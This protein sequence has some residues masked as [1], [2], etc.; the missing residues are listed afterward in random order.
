MTD[1]LSDSDR[2]QDL[3]L[4]RVMLGTFT[5]ELPRLI[6]TLREM[7]AGYPTGHE[8]SSQPELCPTCEGATSIEDDL[9]LAEIC[10]DCEGQGYVTDSFQ[11]RTESAAFTP[12]K[13]RADLRKIDTL[14]R[15]A[16]SVADQLDSV[17]SEW[18]APDGPKLEKAKEA[19]PGCVSCKR[20]KIKI[21]DVW[22]P[23]WEPRHLLSGTGDKAHY[24]ER[25][26]W[27]SDWFLANG[28]NP[29]VEILR[30]RHQGVRI[31]SAVLAKYGVKT[32]TARERQARKAS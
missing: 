25:C 15:Q 26:R 4:S 20:L 7:H 30:L 27:C 1:R 3:V 11:S 21:R 32:K 8:G 2:R 10:P 28:Q 24:D 13:A 29:P 17:R 31:T 5:E 18:L 22:R 12:D 23:V 19:E 14:V 16:R 9:G 6:Q